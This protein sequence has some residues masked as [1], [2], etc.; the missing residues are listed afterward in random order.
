MWQYEKKASY[1]CCT[2]KNEQVSGSLHSLSIS[3]LL[4]LLMS[5]PVRAVCMSAYA[6][7]AESFVSSALLCF[8][9]WH[10]TFAP[11]CRT[12]RMAVI[13]VSVSVSL[14]IS[15]S[16]QSGIEILSLP[17]FDIEISPFGIFYAIQLVPLYCIYYL[18]R[19][20]YDGRHIYII[21]TAKESPYV[22]FTLIK[23][24]KF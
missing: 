2:Y 7:S 10:I 23:L 6:I 21:C 13:S 11:L 22:L 14:M 4:K 15:Y 5:S 16:D 17:F 20:G 3:M 1:P 9:M 12:T 24:Y 8:G 19:E 18:M